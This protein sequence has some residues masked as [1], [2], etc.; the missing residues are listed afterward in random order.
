MPEKN[1]AGFFFIRFPNRRKNV[2]KYVRMFVIH[3]NDVRYAK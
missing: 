2:Y 3:S 1:N